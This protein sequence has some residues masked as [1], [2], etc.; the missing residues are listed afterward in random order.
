M[1]V[2]FPPPH[3]RHHPILK[4]DPFTVAGL[5]KK[6]IPWL[7]IL[8]VLVI[9]QAS[10]V[11]VKTSMTLGQSIPVLGDWFIIHF[12]ENYGMAFGLEFSGEYGKLMLSLFRIVA[13]IFI[14]WYLAKLVRRK[15]HNGL[16]VCI[17]LVMAGALGNI[18]DS[19]F[20]GLLFSQSLFNQVAVFLPEEGGYGSFLHG[21]VVDMLYF[22]IIKGT[23]PSWLPFYADQPFIFFRPVFNIADA[24][25]TTGV[26]LLILFQKRFF[27]RVRGDR[28][29]SVSDEAIQ[30][31]ASLEGG[32]LYGHIDQTPTSIAVPPGEGEPGPH[33]EDDAPQHEQKKV[34]P[35]GDGDSENG[36]QDNGAGPSG[37]GGQGLEGSDQDGSVP[38]KADTQ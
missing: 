38:G 35:S 29:Y 10:K 30:K 23:T 32:G 17:S 2:P 27:G 25:I 5:Q 4:T 34:S 33:E 6:H 1:P 11:L 22:P 36:T 13:V 16:I 19:A 12:T 3:T 26:A 7:V 9:D 24:A 20:Y 18:I 14:G 15:A 8:L 31:A 37:D 28:K 21:K